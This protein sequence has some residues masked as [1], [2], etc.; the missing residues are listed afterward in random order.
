MSQ[1]VDRMSVT[2]APSLLAELDA[3]VEAGEYDSRSEATR[4]A[5]RSFVTEFNHQTD[6]SGNLSGTVV[7]LYVHDHSGVSGAMN[8]LQHDFTETIIAVH[9]VHLSHHLCLE[10]I[11]VDGPGERIEAL[12][13]RLRPLKGVHH[14]KLTV[15]DADREPSMAQ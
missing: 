1:D 15:V 3:V 11:A 8:Q 5:I 4:D 10:S 6:L 7:V 2:L 14:V 12:V 13:S 9:H